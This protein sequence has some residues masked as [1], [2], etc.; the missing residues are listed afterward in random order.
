MEA[1]SGNFSHI[2]DTALCVL[3]YRRL[4][5][6]WGGR[7]CIK[8]NITLS[9]A[10]SFCPHMLSLYSGYCLRQSITCFGLCQ[11]NRLVLP[12]PLLWLHIYNST[13]K[14]ISGR[15]GY[16]CRSFCGLILISGILL[17]FKGWEWLW[18]FFFW[19]STDS[20]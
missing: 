7:H 6:L 12:F 3:S 15:K 17:S 11:L 13:Y 5:W 10:L 20:E 18:L 1:V 14:Y 4:L 19:D 8:A 16:C 9:E 2:A